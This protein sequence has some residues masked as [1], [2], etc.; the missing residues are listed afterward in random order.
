MVNG[1]LNMNYLVKKIIFVF[2]TG[3]IL[4]FFSELVFW[5]KYGSESIQGVS[6]PDVLLTWLGYSFISY[7]FLTVIQE[8][9]I[10]NI[11]ALFLAGAVYGWLAEGV[12]VQTM[13]D[14]FPM[15]LSWTGL[16]W[17]A[18]I[19]IIVGWYM[20][21]KLL[22]EKRYLATLILSSLIGTMY[23][24][25]ATIWWLEP[26]HNVTP[27]L[28]F[29]LYVFVTTAFLMI[30]YWVYDKIQP[31]SFQTSRIEKLFLVSLVSIIFIIGTV[32]VNPLAVLILPPLL[33]VIYV[34]LK[35]NKKSETQSDLLEVFLNDKV[36]TVNYFLLLPIP[37]FTIAVYALALF[38]NL[39]IESSIFFYYPLTVIGA[40]LFIFSM[41]NIFKKR[42][43][44]D[45]L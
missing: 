12:L 19:S 5:A 32:L 2:T 10:R 42:V 35:R 40:F 22:L 45:S 17:H 18:P 7:I 23:G 20:I 11:W 30:S 33:V 27:L 4:L 29:S 24:L 34:A 8:F 6:F 28:E 36:K 9:K 13:Y 41:V 15:N 3:Y 39:E 14:A 37:L 1:S 43:I 21:R 16:A 25:W 38:L 31:F 44:K 26:G